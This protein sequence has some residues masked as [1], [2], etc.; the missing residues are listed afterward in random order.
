MPLAGVQNAAPGAGALARRPG[1][2]RLRPGPALPAKRALQRARQAKTAGNAELRAALATRRANAIPR[3]A[4]NIHREVA[5]A[6]RLPPLTRKDL[7]NTPLATSV[8]GLLLHGDDHA[9]ALVSLSGLADPA[10]VASVAQAHGAQLLDLKNAS[11]SLVSAYRNR[12]LAALAVAAVLL[13]LTVWLALRSPRRVLRVLLPM[14]LTTLLVLAV[15]RGCGVELTLFHLVALILAAGLG[16]DYALFFEHA[17]D[18]YADQLR[19]LH[20]LI[21]C[22]LMTLLV[23]ALLRCRRSRYCARSG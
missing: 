9:T 22:S 20:A 7:Q 21:V 15:L 4:F 12:V 14:A 18:D 16:L 10:A 5:R 8:D 13:S 1:D 3:D 2:R 17:G 6:K 23:F 19:T 11:E